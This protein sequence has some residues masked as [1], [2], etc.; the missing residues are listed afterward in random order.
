MTVNCRQGASSCLDFWAEA[1]SQHADGSIM[2][3]CGVRKLGVQDF[4]V[5]GAGRGREQ[6]L[7]KVKMQNSEDRNTHSWGSK[8]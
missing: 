7:G 4:Y 1:F 8:C 3:R 5:V 6:H 2:G